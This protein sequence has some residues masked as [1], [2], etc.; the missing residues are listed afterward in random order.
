MFLPRWKE[1]GSSIIWYLLFVM[2]LRE[3]WYDTS[4][5]QHSELCNRMPSAQFL[6]LLGYDNGA[7]KM[8]HSMC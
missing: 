3:F 1:T 2:G 5:S 4:F 6:N 7:Y 8:P